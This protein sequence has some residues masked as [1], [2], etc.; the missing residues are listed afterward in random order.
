MEKIL[1]F[2]IWLIGILKNSLANVAIIGNV[3]S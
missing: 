1:S 2:L 3:C